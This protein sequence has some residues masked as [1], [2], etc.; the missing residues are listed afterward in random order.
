VENKVKKQNENGE[1]IK[2]ERGADKDKKQE[3]PK[4]VHRL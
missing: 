3:R 1:K 2:A 4:T